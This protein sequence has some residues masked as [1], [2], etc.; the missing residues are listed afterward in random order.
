MPTQ[1]DDRGFIVAFDDK[2]LATLVGQRKTVD[3]A[4]AEV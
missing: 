2:D 3:A 1:D 4:A